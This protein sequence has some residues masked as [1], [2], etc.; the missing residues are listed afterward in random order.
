MRKSG[1]SPAEGQFPSPKRLF[2]PR[3]LSGASGVLQNF[4]A[5]NGGYRNHSQLSPR[6][7]AGGRL[8]THSTQILTEHLCLSTE[9]AC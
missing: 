2:S 3:L 1:R 4:G 9:N 5:E 7:T 8:P 6:W